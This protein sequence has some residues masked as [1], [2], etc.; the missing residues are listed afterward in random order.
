MPW[1]VFKCHVNAVA[2]DLFE[3]ADTDCTGR[4]FMKRRA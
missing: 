2:F 1:Q 4:H 3:L